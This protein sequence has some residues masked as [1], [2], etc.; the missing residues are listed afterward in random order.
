TEADRPLE[1][2]FNGGDPDLH[3]RFVLVGTDLFELLA[4]GNGLT[5]LFR[6][7]ECLPDLLAWHR[8]VVRT[9]KL[10]AILPSDGDGH[11]ARVSQRTPSIGGKRV[12]AAPWHLDCCPTS[13]INNDPGGVSDEEVSERFRP[14]RPGPDSCNGLHRVAEW[15]DW[16]AFERPCA[17][18]VSID[19]AVVAVVV[20]VLGHEQV[21]LRDVALDG[22]RLVELALEHAVERHEVGFLPASGH[23][24]R[25]APMSIGRHGF[26]RTNHRERSRPTVTDATRARGARVVT[27]IARAAK[28]T[29]RT[30]P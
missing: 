3:R 8:N 21:A 25:S 19:V 22:Q 29:R 23:G 30:T 20:P 14:A 6:I 7:E 2:P 17:V 5:E 26:S 13:R 24:G 10:H 27:V 18:G 1:R 4:S 28:S 9:F 12:P 15:P 11:T 16:R